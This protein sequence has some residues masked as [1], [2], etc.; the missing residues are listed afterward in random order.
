MVFG[1]VYLGGNTLLFLTPK[2]KSFG[3]IRTLLLF[4]MSIIVLIASIITIYWHFKK[5]VP[6]FF[7]LHSWF[8]MMTLT[9]MIIYVSANGYLYGSRS[10]QR[11]LQSENSDSIESLTNI[12]LIGI[13][14]LLMSVVTSLLGL[15]QLT[16]FIT[17]DIQTGQTSYQLL[18][19]VIGIFSIAFT[20]F[21]VFLVSRLRIRSK[22]R[23]EWE[24]RVQMAVDKAMENM[25]ASGAFDSP[26]PPPSTKST[27]KS[28]TVSSGTTK[29]QLKRSK[30]SSGGGR[31]K[32]TGKSSRSSRVSTTS[33]GVSIG[34]GS[35]SQLSSKLSKQKSNDEKKDKNSQKSSTTSSTTSSSLLSKK[36]KSSSSLGHHSTTSSSSS[37]GGS[38]IVSRQDGVGGGNSSKNNSEITIPG[39][40][41]SSIKIPSM[42]SS[43]SVLSNDINNKSS[44]ADDDDSA[45]RMKT[46]IVTK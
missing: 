35:T 1:L 32:R 9:L 38:N 30:R 28:T 18:V 39:S 3:I 11:I 20:L 19:N 2:R 31:K 21:I 42:T 40:T 37:G 16:S 23:E 7:T 46:K 43:K 34:G 5:D 33:S 13:S 8:G 6:N 22:S 17:S 24:E 4:C 41:N 36:Q 29:Q 26:P 12:R 45:F 14:T 44:S 10:G 15:N 25:Q 27:I